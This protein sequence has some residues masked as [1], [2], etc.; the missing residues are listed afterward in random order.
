M[1]PK[2]RR[3]GSQGRT[4]SPVASRGASQAKAQPKSKAKAKAEPKVAVAGQIL[5]AFE[6]L[7]TNGDGTIHQD[8]LKEVMQALDRKTWTDK[9]I[10]LIMSAIDVDSKGRVDYDEFVRW[11]MGGSD[12]DRTAV[13]KAGEARANSKPRARGEGSA[14]GA[15]TSDADS[16]EELEKVL[17]KIFTFYDEDQDGQI[18]RIEWLDGEEKRLGKLD[19]GP[20][21]RKEAI[22]WFKEAGAVGTP[23]D[24]M[25]LSKENFKTALVK[26]VA[27]ESGISASAEP[28]RLAAFLRE[29]RAVAFAEVVTAG[30]AA[31]SSSAPQPEGAPAEP[32]TYPLTIKFKDLMEATR[33]ATYFKR[34]VLVL[35]NDKTEVETFLNYR[36]TQLI[37][38]KQIINETCIQKSKSKEDAQAEARKQLTA[39]MNSSGF[40]KPLH[41][42]LSNSAFDLTKFCGDEVPADI[43]NPHLWT[44]EEA[45][46]RGFFE[47]GHKANLEIEDEKKWKDFYVIITSTFDSERAKEFLTDKIPHFNELAILLID[48]ASFEE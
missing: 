43:F 32:P 1:A 28:G 39:A 46:K 38:C 2:Q 29:S 5:K 30:G 22:A 23:V 20:K 21:N 6:G 37:D 8:E 9:K 4:G 13:L 45:F 19:F 36:S 35:S 31:A 27:E 47:A 10:G 40:T 18:E 7:D 17:E 11:V 16:Q 33:E 26:K 41:I 42:R 3:P 15:G 14:G 48:P 12:K 24:G 25:F 34:A 44:I